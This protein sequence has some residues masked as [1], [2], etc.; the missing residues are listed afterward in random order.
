MHT[1]IA[2]A[3]T[4]IVSFF[5]GKIQGNRVIADIQAVVAA[6][7]LRAETDAKKVIA[8]VRAKL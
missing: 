2:V 1:V 7:E 4:A 8:A 6:A 5:V 3:V